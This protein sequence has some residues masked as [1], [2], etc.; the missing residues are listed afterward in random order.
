MIDNMRNNMTNQFFP[1]FPIGFLL[2]GLFLFVVFFLLLVGDIGF[3]GDDWW[4]F[5]IPYWNSFPGSLW[6]YAQ[7]SSRPIE[8]LYWISMYELFGLNKPAFLAGSISLLAVSCVL[9]SKSLYNAFPGYGS[10]AITSGLLA[11]V[12]SP[13]ANLTFMLHTDN[14]RISSL[15]FWT[16]CLLFQSWAKNPNRLVT[17]LWPIIFYCLSALTYENCVLLIFSIPFL[18]YP[19]FKS[20]KADCSSSIFL[21][22]LAVAIMVC[23]GFFLTIRF[24]VFE[25]GAVGHSSLFPSAGLICSYVVTLFQYLVYPLKNVDANVGNLTWALGFVSFVFL[26]LVKYNRGISKAYPSSNEFSFKRDLAYMSL[27]S[28]SVM[29]L[30][31]APYLIAGYSPDLGFTSQSRIFSSAGFGAAALISIL[32][33]MSDLKKSVG[34]VIGFFLLTF[35]FLSALSQISLREDWIQAKEY[36]DNVTSKLLTE[37]PEV[38]KGSNFLFLDLQWYL[39]DKAVVFQ[40][41]DGIKEWIRILYKNPQVNAFFLYSAE[42]S[43]DN[44]REKPAVI[45]PKGLKVRGSALEGLLPLNSLI[46]MER[47]GDSLELLSSVKDADNKILALWNDIESIETNHELILRK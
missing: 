19:V 37:V 47:K 39:G 29:C 3:Q 27:C 8:G 24:M 31:V 12:I 18:T 7:E 44:D 16:S 6:I 11:F 10:W 20:Q 17:L 1:K 41:V 35:V 25:G 22:R 26:V 40:G 36:R 45:T 14:S 21:M 5:G 42:S 28:I 30:G 4:I 2:T 46:L 15:F 34:R 43:G 23:F 33:T 13:L 32:A 38:K 9:M